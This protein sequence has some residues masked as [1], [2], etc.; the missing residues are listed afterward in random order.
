MSDVGRSSLGRRATAIP[1]TRV[2][3]AA[4]ERARRGCPPG[5]RRSRTAGPRSR[6]RSRRRE[7]VGE[8]QPGEHLAG[9]T[10]RPAPAD[11]DD[12]RPVAAGPNVL[13]DLLD[14]GLRSARASV[15]V[16]W[17]VAP[18]QLVQPLVRALSPAAAGGR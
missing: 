4:P 5:S 15:A 11:A 18:E 16:T 10:D 12:E 2:A 1:T 8:L 14:E 17:T 9:R 6:R 3:G 13:G 7:L